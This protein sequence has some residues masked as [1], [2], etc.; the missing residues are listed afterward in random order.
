MASIF[1]KPGKSVW[2]IDYYHNGKRIRHSLKTTDERIA[3]KK[4]R[5]L[6]GELVT[7][8]LE[9]RSHTPIV[10]FLEAFTSHLAAGRTR[11]SYKNDISYLRVFFGPICEALKPGTTHNK[12]YANAQQLDGIN[13]L[14]SRH[15]EVRTPEELSAKIMGKF[16]NT[17]IT[18]DG[19]SPKTANR[20]R[21]VLHVMFNF[22]I[23]QHD[24]RS[25]HQRYPNPVDAVPRCREEEPVI[26]FLTL[27]QIDEQ[28]RVLHS[29]PDLHAMVAVLIYAGLRREELLWLT[30]A[31]V[32][33]KT[34]MIRVCKKTVGDETWWP[35]TRRNRRVPISG[36]LQSVLDRHRKPEKAI[37]F[38]PSPRGHRWDCDNFSQDLREINRK[39][40]PPWGCLD[41]RHT[42]GSHLAMKGE[43]LF[44]ISTL[45]GNSPEICRRHYATLIPEEM[46][47][48]VGFDSRP[49][50]VLRLADC[51]SA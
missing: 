15:V 47:D 4:L 10:P 28:L 34:R 16:I 44:K 18:R 46:R 7:G 41:F 51:E 12:R 45:M 30:P 37:W 32:D 5:K 42:F 21:E 14:K 29:R 25:P 23:R 39:H 2:W 27:D 8:E 43:S 50:S 36:V 1:R 48:S 24:L 20:M 3:T 9:S 17:R 22:A 6:E 13:R 31:D 49:R 26:R 11:K 19:I 38:F 33:L 40:G 35:K